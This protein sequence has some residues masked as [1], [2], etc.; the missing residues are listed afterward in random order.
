MQNVRSATRMDGVQAP[1]I[2]VVGDIIRQVP[3]TISLGQGIVHYGPPP[4]AIDAARAALADP[5]THEYSGGSGRPD[6]LKRIAAKLAAE[7]GIDVARGSA[8]MVT[9]GANMAFMHA[10]LAISEP[11]DEIILP[12]PFYFNHEMAIQMAGCRA[13]PVPT[14]ASYQLHLDALSRAIT[15]RTR[16]IVTISPNNP[17]GAVFP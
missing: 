11:G 5:A 2:P 16:A 14:D 3:G 6:L 7:N 10:V 8:V 13:V 17:T 15:D 12:V 4:A 1:I 9:A